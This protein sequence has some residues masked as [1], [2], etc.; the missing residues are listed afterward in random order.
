MGAVY[1]NNK[2][3]IHD[4]PAEDQGIL[5][6]ILVDPSQQSPTYTMASLTADEVT[7]ILK[8]LD[9]MAPGWSPQVTLM[10]TEA[11]YA[12]IKA[13]QLVKAQTKQQFRGIFAQGAA[14][15]MRWLRAKDIGNTILNG[16]VAATLGIYGGAS[17][18]A[19]GY[20]S[21]YLATLASQST[22]HLVPSQTMLLYGALVY[23]GFIDPTEV[24]VVDAIRFTLYGVTTPTQTSDF[25][26]IKTFDSNELPS[27]KLEKPI[28]IP[29]LGVQVVDV[30]ANRAGDTKVQPV[31]VLIGRS[32][33]LGL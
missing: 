8:K 3:L 26:M 24:P 21:T 6:D 2:S 28:I 23:M 10:A 22:N 27:W 13:V 4:Y 25:K 1:T 33:D 17:P 29:P 30:F 20:V 31:A 19:G 5:Q 15:D 16:P 9:S 7:T 32:Q 18:P 12:V 11:A 14:L